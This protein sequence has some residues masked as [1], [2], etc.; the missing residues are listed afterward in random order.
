MTIFF[1]INLLLK[2]ATGSGTLLI[3]V[4]EAQFQTLLPACKYGNGQGQ[5]AFSLRPPAYPHNPI[6][7][8]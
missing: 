4:G 1:T 2:N 6:V 7:I 3:A 5:A 8:S